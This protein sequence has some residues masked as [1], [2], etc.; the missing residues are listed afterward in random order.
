M[1][2]LNTQ[3]SQINT[4]KKNTLTN[5]AVIAYGMNERQRMEQKGGSSSWKAHKN[6]GEWDGK[7][8]AC[9]QPAQR[10]GR[11][12][13]L[14]ESGLCPGETASETPEPRWAALVG[15]TPG[16][17]PAW[18][19]WPLGLPLPRDPTP[20]HPPPSNAHPPR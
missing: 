6:Q 9:T 18:M 16:S 13:G 5:T 19:N 15:D 1:L 2:Q 3:H 11:M 7:H 10:G 17:S 12:L 8:P 14:Q 4:L 20:Q